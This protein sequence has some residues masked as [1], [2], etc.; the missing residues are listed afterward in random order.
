MAQIES[1]CGFDV[2]NDAY[3]PFEK[4]MYEPILEEMETLGFSFKKETIIL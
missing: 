4:E 2:E 3:E 1:P